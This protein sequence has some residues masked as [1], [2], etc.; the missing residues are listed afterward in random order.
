MKCSVS[1]P[2]S[3]KS[4]SVENKNNFKSIYSM[5]F[6]LILEKKSLLGNLGAGLGA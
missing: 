3:K 6:L 1:E 2:K 4:Y 5:Y